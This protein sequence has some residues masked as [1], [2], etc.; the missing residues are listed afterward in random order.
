M[1]CRINAA[2]PGRITRLEIP[3][4]PGVRF[5]SFLYSGCSV[6]PHYDSMVAKLI[7]HGTD[8]EHALARMD[9][10]LGELIIEGI[11]TNKAKQRWIINDKVFRSGVFGTSY[12]QS[13]AGE[14]EHA[15]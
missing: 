13:V 11:I 12:Y 15:T 9:R 10:A 6:P 5:D 14:V 8:R 2:G 7:V 4:G 1:E 3:G